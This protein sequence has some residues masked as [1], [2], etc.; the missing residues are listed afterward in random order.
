MGRKKY[1]V[2]LDTVSECGVWDHTEIRE[3]YGESP[4]RALEAANWEVD[5][6][7]WGAAPGCRILVSLV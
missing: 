7:L 2:K 3:V 5:S 1:L 6:G 4:E